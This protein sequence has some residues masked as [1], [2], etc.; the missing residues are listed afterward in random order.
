MKRAKV[1]GYGGLPG[2]SLEMASFAGGV[3]LDTKY[4]VDSQAEMSSYG[5]Q[6]G[7][8]PF[9]STAAVPTPVTSLRMTVNYAQ[10]MDLL[11]TDQPN[12]FV[13]KPVDILIPY[14]PWN[15]PSTSKVGSLYKEIYSYLDKCAS[16]QVR[17]CT[18]PNGAGSQ[19][20][21]D[22]RFSGACVASSC[23]AGYDL[24]AGS[25]IHKSVGQSS[26]ASEGLFVS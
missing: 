16:W 24:Q 3:V 1:I 10:M 23:S 18:V 9:T 17:S 11:V 2:E 20:C 21:V 7:F 25:C 6:L 26:S 19:R 15:I 8:P 4:Y 12:Q 22:G 5:A 14:Y 13:K